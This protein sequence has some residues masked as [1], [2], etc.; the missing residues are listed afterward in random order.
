VNETA[1]VY[2]VDTDPIM[3]T[4]AQGEITAWHY[5][6]RKPVWVRWRDGIITEVSAAATTSPEDLWIAPGLFDLQVNGFAGV[7]FQQDGLEREDLF[8]AVRGLSK[9]G[10]TRFLLTLIT[11]T[12]PKLTARLRS[13]HQLRAGC[14]GLERAIAGWHIEGPFLSDEAGFHG[15]HPRELMLDP[16]PEHIHELREIAG[17]DPLLLTVAP[18]RR[19]AL[20][21]I[22]LASRLGIR[23]SLG[24]TNA[25]ADLLARAVVAG[26]RGFTHLGNGCAALLDRRDNILWRVFETPGLTVSLIPDRVHVSPAL[27]RIMHRML[28]PSAVIYVSDAMAAGGAP[29][30]HYRLGALELEV[31]EDRI[32]RQPGSPYL[33][34]SALNP[35]DGVD[36]AAQML[37]CPWQDCWQ[38][39][40]ESSARFMGLQSGLSP[41]DTLDAFLVNREPDG[42]GL[43]LQALAEFNFENPT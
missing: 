38:R 6:T 29:P 5:R 32:V 18:E 35:A 7:D 25:P 14:P 11:D 33:A 22:S 2:F 42:K 20:E 30:G 31:G 4:L 8:R 26:A 13:L 43:R 10:C 40:S 3:A 16:S 21:A 24:H 27:F 36:F 12:W 1:R 19:G 41:G 39:Y 34:G 9:Y 28:G 17:P 23:V 37:N 15:A